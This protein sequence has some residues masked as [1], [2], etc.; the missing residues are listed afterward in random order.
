[1]ARY[2]GPSG[3]E[4][5]SPTRAAESTGVRR[6][7]SPGKLPHGRRPVR[8]PLMGNH[9]LRLLLLAGACT[10]LAAVIFVRPPLPQDLA[11]HHF[12]DQRTLL[13]IPHFAN[14]VSNVPFLL[15]GAAGLIL[16]PRRGV[17]LDERERWP[18]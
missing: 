17:F 11:Y 15:V 6:R 4:C 3:G 8:M 18:Y 7:E 9:P 12:V 10:P 5:Y 1:M 16:G 13:G 2:R 14:V